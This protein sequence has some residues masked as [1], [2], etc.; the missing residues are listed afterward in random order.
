METMKPSIDNCMHDRRGF[1]VEGK[2]KGIFMFYCKKKNKQT[3]TQNK[4]K[5]LN[6]N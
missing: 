2:E 5:I 6:F 1:G 3:N 4:I